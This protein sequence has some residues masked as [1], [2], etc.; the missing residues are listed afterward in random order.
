[1]N[2]PFSS[3]FHRYLLTVGLAAAFGLGLAQA[4]ED[5]DD[6]DESKYGS[7][8]AY[9]PQ[10]TDSEARFQEGLKFLAEEMK[11]DPSKVQE[12]IAAKTPAS[13]R[14]LGIQRWEARL[15]RGPEY[16]AVCLALGE[17]VEEANADLIRWTKAYASYDPSVK[18]PKGGAGETCPKNIYRI[19]LLPA[20]QKNLSDEAR[21]VL[22][23][24]ALAW[25]N[26]MSRI[27]PNASLLHNATAGPWRISNSENHDANDKCATLL[28]LEI[29]N[30]ASKKYNGQTRLSDGRTVKE[31]YDAWV[32]YWKENIR[33]RAREGLFYEIA[34]HGT[35]GLATTRPYLDFYDVASDPVL[36]RLAGDMATLNFAQLAGEYEPKTGIRG[37]FSQTRAKGPTHQQYGSHWAK[38][39]AFAFGWGDAC[40]NQMFP[41][42]THLFL[43]TYR[44]PAIV[45]AIARGPRL[46]P[47]FSV[48][49]NFGLGGDK[50]DSIN[51]VRFENGDSYIRRTSW[52]APE[53]MLSGITVDPNRD[54]LKG[55]QQAR[56]AGVSFSNG[57]NDRLAFIGHDAKDHGG[58]SDHNTIVGED[59]LVVG[60]MPQAE[61]VETLAYVSGGNLWGS[62][63]ED[64]S[65]WQFFRSGD[66][67][68]ALRFAG[69]FEVR[70]AYQ[71]MGY[72]IVPKDKDAPMV[73]QTGRAADYPGGFDA[74]KKAVLEKTNFDCPEHCLTY[75]SL[76][77]DTYKF[78]TQEKKMPELNGKPFDLNPPDTYSSPYLTMVHGSDKA[79]IKY[80]GHEDLI[81]DFSYQKTPEMASSSR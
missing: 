44:P 54:Y 14:K 65:G 19:R 28:G 40:S 23:D 67:F 50:V 42:Q 76:K 39:L 47:Y 68:C 63:V 57:V 41:W 61:S 71:K 43:T 48:M 78:W 81:L 66:G 1:M 73:V 52:I 20:C 30:G 7:F 22:D 75:T 55:N 10:A 8:P 51:N 12:K 79:T 17:G 6:V 2:M 5:A 31:H 16:D 77:G 53:Y 26:K 46:P 35:Y 9:K 11:P 37:A 18:L 3:P 45:T 4:Q 62:R 64:P 60:R 15:D 49:R 36:K 21:E 70:D 56:L 27:D 59:C 32:A 29:L 74:F 13:M 58:M 38:N 69:P 25:C 34:H 24:S 80:P 33:Q 72:Y